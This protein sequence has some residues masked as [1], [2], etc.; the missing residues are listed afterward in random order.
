MSFSPV[1]KHPWF[2]GQA[3]W[4]M[5]SSD[6]LGVTGRQGGVLSIVSNELSDILDGAGRQTD[7]ILGL[8]HWQNMRGC[9]ID[10][11]LGLDWVD[12]LLGLRHGQNMRG[13]L[14]DLW[15]VLNRLGCFVSLSHEWGMWGQLI[16][17]WLELDWVGHFIGLQ[18]ELGSCLIDPWLE[19]N[20]LSSWVEAAM[21][22]F[23]VNAP[24][25]VTLS[26]SGVSSWLEATL[27]T[28]GE[29]SVVQ[30][31]W[32]ACRDSSSTPK[33]IWELVS[34]LPRVRN[35]DLRNDAELYEAPKA[36]VLDCHQIFVLMECRACQ[37]RQ[38][39]FSPIQFHPVWASTGLHN[40]GCIA[41][42]TH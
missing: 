24:V 39:D 17:L 2:E 26:V 42:S 4:A 10:L 7:F 32:L 6:V 3:Y 12:L 20:E 29:S 22:I 1:K 40:I 28:S 37:L 31:A 11:W 41:R 34:F 33:I 19:L 21:L 23:D 14:A 5:M 25:E 15:L 36:W 16:E 8:M 35:R 27:S 18:L 9:L 13:C 38:H 30:A